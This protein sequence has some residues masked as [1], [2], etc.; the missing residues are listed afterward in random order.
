[1]T[2]P[3][4]ISVVVVNSRQARLVGTISMLMQDVEDSQ[5][6]ALYYEE[7]KLK[8]GD[9]VRAGK[10]PYK[11]NYIKAVITQQGL[12]AYDIIVCMVNNSSIFAFPFLG[13]NRRLMLWDSMFMNAFIAVP[14]N[15]ECIALLYRFSGNILF[16]KFESALCSFRTFSNRYDP[17]PYHVV[18]VFNVPEEAKASYNH[19]V[20]GRYSEIDDLWKLKI[21][22]FHGFDIDGH[23]GQILFRDSRLRNKIEENLDITL[24]ED[25][26]LHS[27]IDRN[28]EELNFEFYAPSIKSSIDKSK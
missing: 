21:L 16:T 15:P 9:T 10:T 12:V 2:Q 6:Q 5:I 28:V 24:S 3:F 27:I 19:F 7:Y 22:D 13:G 4:H 18:F 17:D 20:N 26:E 8:I 14:D 23:T 1:M 25:T 11:V